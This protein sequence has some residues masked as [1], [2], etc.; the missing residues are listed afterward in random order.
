MMDC[1]LIMLDKFR[2]MYLISWLPCVVT[3]GISLPFDE[4]LESFQSSELSVCDNSFHFVF[5]LA[6]NEVRW[7]S[8]EVWSVGLRFMIERQQGRVKYIMNSPIDG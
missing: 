6:V 7:W 8:G 3:L 1:G 5:F 4:V 2:G